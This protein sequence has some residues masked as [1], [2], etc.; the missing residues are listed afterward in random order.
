LSVLKFSPISSC[1]AFSLP[2]SI[3]LSQRQRK[4]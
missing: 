4:V 3:T 2:L 1:K